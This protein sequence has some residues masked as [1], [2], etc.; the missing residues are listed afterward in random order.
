MAAPC[1]SPFSI[2]PAAV[3]LNALEPTING[4]VEVAEPS[5]KRSP[6]RL[7]SVIVDEAATIMPTVE[8]GVIKLSVSVSGKAQL[9]LLPPA[10]VASVPQ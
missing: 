4:P 3:M 6:V 2:T 9:E 8:V 5:T 10:P 7:R 1:H